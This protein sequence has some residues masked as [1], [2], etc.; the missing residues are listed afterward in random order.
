MK[1]DFKKENRGKK[2][3]SYLLEPLINRRNAIVDNSQ[4]V[5]EEDLT[6]KEEEVVNVEDSPKVIN[7]NKRRNR[8]TS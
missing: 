3:R 8:L 7:K 6:E 5:E 2:N 1:K 4:E